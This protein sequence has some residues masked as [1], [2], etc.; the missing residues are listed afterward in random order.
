M[1]SNA[2]GTTIEYD[3]FCSSYHSTV[4]R[5]ANGTYKTWGEGLANS[6]A[7]N[8]LAPL[9]INSTNYPAL[10][11]NILKAHLASNRS[12]TA[13]G[14]VLTTTGLFAWGVEGSI[15]HQNI[16]TSTVF[17]KI[18][19]GGNTQGLPTGV[20]PL[21]VK[22][23]F[24][25]FKTMALVT[26]SGEVWV[27][28]HQ[29]ENTG[30]GLT[31][32]L[33]NAAAVL[34]YKVTTTAAGNP[35][36]SNV[37]AVRGNQNTMVALTSTGELFTWGTETYL[38]NNS[39]IASRNRATAMTL[40]SA[41]AIKMIGVTRDESN[42]KPTY[43]VLN[44]NGNLYAMGGNNFRQIGDWT[45]TDRLS[46]VQ[47][48][49]T[50]TTGPVMNNIHW[51]SPNEHDK[52]FAA[53]NV[54][55]ADSTNYNWGESNGL[56][57]GRAA[58][59]AANP[60]I[61]DGITAANKI[62]AVETGGHTSMLVKKC[63]DYFGYVGHR[64]NG[65]MGDGTANTTNEAVYTFATA[66]VFI[67]GATTVDVTVSGTP[68]LS[69][70][71][72]YCNNSTIDVT[73]DPPGGTFSVSGPASL[74]GNLLTFTGSGNT[75]VN[76]VYTVPTPGCPSSAI[77]TE[78]FLTENCNLPPNATADVSSTN[79]DT[80]VVIAVP[81]N[82][83]DASGLN[84]TSVTITTNPTNGTVTVNPVTGAVTYT[85][86]ANFNGTDQFIYQICDNGTPAL[87]DTALVTITVVPVNDPPIANDNVVVTQL[88]EDGPDGTVNVI[89][90]D[91]DIDGNPTAPINGPGQFTVD[92]D[93]STAGV[94][95]SFTNST[96]TWTLNT[97][98]G[99]VTFDP[100]TNYNGTSTITYT[101]CDAG[102][103]CDNA[104]ITFV[105]APVNDAPLANVNTTTT[106]EDTQVVINVPANDTDV[107]GLNLT[108]VTITS[109]PTNGT[110]T[111]NP[112]TGA[113][114]YTPNEN[115]NGTDQ[116]IY[117]ICDNGTPALC[118]T[119]LVTITVNAVNDAPL[120]NVNTTT[121]NEDTQVVIN[122]PANDT[123]VEGLN[124]T[125]VTIASN[126]AN[127]TVTVN[128]TTGAVT[129][130]PNAN[131]NGTDQFIYQ[132]CDNGTPAL[133]DTALV[134]ITVNAVNDGLIVDNEYITTFS[135]IPVGG[136]LTDIGDSD[137]D[138][139]LVASTTPVDGPS[140]GTIVINPNGTYTY[141][142][143][144]GFTGNDTVVVQI[145]DD[146]SPLPA[147]CVNDTI[148]ILVDVCIN[149]PAADCDGD[150]VTNATEVAD[151][152]DANDPCD[153]EIASQTVTPSAAWGALDC[154]NDGLTNDEEL[155]GGTDPLN[156]DTDGDGV[157]D[158]TEV[159]DGTDANNPCDLEIA[160]QTVTPSA[161]WGALDCDNDGLSNDEELTGGTDP[162]NPDTD[163][164]GVL[165]GT[166]V[167]DG[168]DA[169]DPCDLEIASQTVTPSAAWGALDCDN[170]GLSNDEEL[171]GGTD[172]LNQDTDGDGVLDGTEVAD[173]TDAND[174]CDLEIASQTVTPSAAW[175]ALDCDN[176][177]L[178]NDQEVLGGTDPLNPDTDGD[179]VLDGIEVI[180]ETDANDPCDLLIASQTVTPSA[181][182]GALDCDGDGVLN[183]QEYEQGSNPLDPCSP[184]RC[185]IIIPEAFTPDGDGINDSFEIVGIE[186]APDNT[187]IIFNRW[188]NVVFETSNYQNN[189]IGT[190]NVNMTIGGEELPTGTYFYL[191]DTKT[192]KYGVMKGYVYLQR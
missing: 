40:P 87:C 83:T 19:V 129:Y 88:T 119:A 133:C 190:S 6:G 141:T 189:W 8:V 172:P 63:E 11:G 53:I 118:D 150:G 184:N 92:L 36:L 116:F 96:G 167:A 102:G 9:E 1:G 126:P 64:I 72:L 128:P 168:T 59:G 80:P 33:S 152:T 29:G 75:T 154:D 108:S 62:L 73:A 45:T 90:N 54:L 183:E 39:L 3:N 31:G 173:G 43:Y 77:A 165:D 97:S 160:S 95:T 191:F 142:P 174:P 106:N 185:E 61:P 158:G 149:N 163:G 111:V 66:V 49:Y 27:L 153:L 12:G 58:A 114:T 89:T 60:A 50:S 156:P 164:D 112:V 56:M 113:V 78:V 71:G 192:E 13:Q 76:L 30:T 20:S 140:N 136:D 159:A 79:E 51:I 2:D 121:T 109:N 91:T 105:V 186:Q 120:A 135:N 130:T 37:V 93:P 22:M 166:E 162:L 21:D 86:N 146:G 134:T 148:F 15:I 5:T 151:G 44:S 4:V 57:L 14:I 26:C 18:T 169:N 117:Q 42:L 16:T 178:T 52:A 70:G 110:V 17:Q 46:W 28:T 85:P 175:G 10:T 182:W 131:F 180:D 157:L 123:D 145:C 176:D 177:G 171:T 139:N 143:N 94:Q 107:E 48:R 68:T 181:A 127:G 138:G 81:A 69:P 188:G 25:T 34:W 32:P 23:I 82:D 144:T 99:V 115:F 122:V 132:I 41:N 137:I 179:G 155:T 103:L 47:P 161:A 187:I 55:T 84:V 100:A 101:L 147:I 125:S 170:D 74:S 24:T 35:A 7:A 98:T 65:S 104:I 124:L 38:G 67:C